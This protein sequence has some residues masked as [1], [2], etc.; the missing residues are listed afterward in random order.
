VIEFKLWFLPIIFAPAGL[1]VNEPLSLSVSPA[2]EGSLYIPSFP[3]SMTEGLCFNPFMVPSLRGSWSGSSDR[4][5][6]MLAISKG[7]S[8]RIL[9]LASRSE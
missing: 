2:L 3:I 6:S 4:S 8:E 1:L 7:L 9:L 5:P